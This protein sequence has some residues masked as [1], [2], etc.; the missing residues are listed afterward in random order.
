MSLPIYGQ[1]HCCLTKS[2]LSVLYTLNILQQSASHSY[3]TVWPSF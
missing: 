3:P 2:M 1:S